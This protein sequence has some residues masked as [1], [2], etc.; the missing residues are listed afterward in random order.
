MDK[1]L[2]TSWKQMPEWWGNPE[3][4]FECW[5]KVYNK[6]YGTYEVYVFGK[7]DYGKNSPQYDY[8]NK[9]PEKGFY[10]ESTRYIKGYVDHSDWNFCV[11]GCYSG[12]VGYAHLNDILPQSGPEACK[13][14]DKIFE[15]E[16][17]Y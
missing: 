4:G 2:T 7:K 10:D 5:G 6:N 14:L 3:L 16:K 15:K 11:R 1:S 17:I 12:S 13:M 9:D 8:T